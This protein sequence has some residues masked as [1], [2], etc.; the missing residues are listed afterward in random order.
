MANQGM[1]RRRQ[2]PTEPPRADN[3]NR[4]LDREIETEMELETRGEV[5]ERGRQPG[6]HGNRSPHVDIK[7]GTRR[8]LEN[9]DV[10][11]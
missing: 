9:L 11:S 6:A 1:G 10:E 8:D 7:P 4:A 3:R 2:G 5:H